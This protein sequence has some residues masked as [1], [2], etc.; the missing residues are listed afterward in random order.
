MTFHPTTWRYKKSVIKNLITDLILCFAVSIIYIDKGS[1]GLESIY[2]N[3]TL[4]ESKH[5]KANVLKYNFP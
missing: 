5:S 3:S 4:S 2:I 1:A